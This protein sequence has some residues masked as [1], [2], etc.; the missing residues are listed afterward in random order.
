MTLPPKICPECGEEYVHSAQE[1]IHCDVPLV[2]EA[3]LAEA[4]VEE[5]A[6]SSDLVSVRV[7]SAGWALALSER[8]VEAGIPHRVEAVAGDS[9]PAPGRA[10]P[11]A[12]LVRPQDV[13]RA[14]G[15]DAEQMQREIPDL[16]E[17]W[18]A[19]GAEAEGCPACGAALAA[20]AA[21]CPDC[22]LALVGPE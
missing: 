15:I 18:D 8:L 20:D 7:A 4:P 17:G 5:L 13:G 10:H 19:P 21:E 22:G 2:L 11:Y 14:R 16:P 6:P 9:S 1:C 3:E 12:V